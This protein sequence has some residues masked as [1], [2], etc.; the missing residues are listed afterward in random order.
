MTADSITLTKQ[1]VEQ[2]EGCYRL[3]GSRVSLDSVV[4]SF[5]DNRS[6]ERIVQSFPTLSL[7]QVYGAIAFYLANREIVDVYLEEGEAEFSR[8]RQESQQNNAELYA[9]LEAARAQSL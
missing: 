8:L 5:R 2:R 9:K 4:Y 7:E 1:Y 3:V 6:P